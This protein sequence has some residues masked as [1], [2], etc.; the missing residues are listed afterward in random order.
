[1]SREA[2]FALNKATQA[3][4]YISA[5]HVQAMPGCVPVNTPAGLRARCYWAPIVIM[6]SIMFGL[7]CVKVVERG[8]LKRTG[9]PPPAMVVLLRDSIVY[10][11]GSLSVVLTNLLLST[12]GDVS[13]Q[14]PLHRRFTHACTGGFG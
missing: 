12:F 14:L 2:E 5:I 13:F 1:M 6:V 3:L 10:Y 8:F 4:T 11:A 9:D 7:A